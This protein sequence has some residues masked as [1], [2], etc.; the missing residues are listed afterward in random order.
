MDNTTAA[1]GAAATTTACAAESPQL[2]DL[3]PVYTIAAFAAASGRT[4]AEIEVM[5][6]N[7]QILALASS[8]GPDQL[9]AFQFDAELRPLDRLDLVLGVLGGDVI[10]PWD[11]ATWLCAPHPNLSGRSPVWCLRH[12]V[13]SQTVVVLAVA[14]WIALQRTLRTAARP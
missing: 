3:G 14:K 12:R 13:E 7:G 10:E 2:A 5:I 8:D 9:P 11:L 1:T 6:G 4:P